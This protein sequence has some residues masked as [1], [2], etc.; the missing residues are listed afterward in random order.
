MYENPAQEHYGKGSLKPCQSSI[1][2]IFLRNL[3]NLSNLTKSDS[4]LCNP[5]SLASNHIPL[6][7]YEVSWSNEY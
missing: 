4:D 6:Q 2:E 5:S 1:L 7:A 3:Q